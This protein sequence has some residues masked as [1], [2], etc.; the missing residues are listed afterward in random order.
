MADF[1]RLNGIIGVLDRGDVA[2]SSFASMDIITAK[3]MAA[4]QFD[5]IIYE[6]EHGPW[7]IVALGNCL[8]YMLDRGA[9]AASGS[10][11]PSV[12]P[13]ARVPVN[14]VEQGQWHA[15]QAL[16]SGVYGVVW[17]HIST[18]EEAYNAVSA[19]RYPRLEK[20]P[21]YEPR[22]IRGD[23]PGRA[24]HYWGLT[25]QEYYAKADVWP[26]DPNGEIIVIIQIEDTA[27]IVNL[28]EILRNVPGIGVVLIGEGDLG[29][30]LGFPRQY[31]H[32]ILLEAISEIVSICQQYDV[33]VGHPHANA[34]NMQRILDEGFRF[35]MSGPTQSYSGLEKGLKLT[36][37]SQLGNITS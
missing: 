27:G 9:I 4:S 34:K 32:P 37:R 16:D 25:Q 24:C 8:Q 29:Q 13:L 28:S 36:N 5:G 20:A 14:G 26:L 18:V 17:P 12:T 35:I 1:N 2:F 21:L 7:D 23:G 15:K 11:A 22:G 31:D 33:I 6:G 30:E 3:A 10:I 19:C